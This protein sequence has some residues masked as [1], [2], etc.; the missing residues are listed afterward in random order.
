MSR[1]RYELIQAQEAIDHRGDRTHPAPLEPVMA[2]IIMAAAAL[3]YAAVTGR[4]RQRRRA[5]LRI[6]WS[7]IRLNLELFEPLNKER[8]ERSDE[9]TYYFYFLSPGYL[10]LSAEPRRLLGAR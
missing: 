9:W 7:L 4:S 5:A 8:E 10:A 1:Q 3:V 2:I 6:L